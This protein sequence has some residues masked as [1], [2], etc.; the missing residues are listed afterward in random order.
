MPH[1]I[2]VDHPDVCAYLSIAAADVSR[3][4][5]EARIGPRKGKLAKPGWFTVSDGPTWWRAVHG[6]IAHP[7][8]VASV[9]GKEGRMSKYEAERIFTVAALVVSNRP[10]HPAHWAFWAWEKRWEVANIVHEVVE[11]KPMRIAIPKGI[12][13]INPHD[14][15]Y[16]ILCNQAAWCP[17]DVPFPLGTLRTYFSNQRTK[18]LEKQSA[19]TECA[20]EQGPAK[21]KRKTP[22]DNGEMTHRGASRKR[23]KR[24]TIAAGSATE[25]GVQRADSRSVTRARAKQPVRQLPMRE[26]R[27]TAR[28]AV[29]AAAGAE[30][31]ATA[32][33][34]GPLVIKIIPPSKRAGEVAVATE[35]TGAPSECLSPLQ[36]AVKK[37]PLGG[38]RTPPSTQIIDTCFGSSPLTEPPSSPACSMLSDVSHSSPAP[39][40]PW[41]RGH[42]RASSAAESDC[43]EISLACS[44]AT[45]VPSVLESDGGSTRPGTPREMNAKAS[46]VLGEAA[47]AEENSIACRMPVRSSARI[48]E[49]KEGSNTASSL[50]SIS[51]SPPA[52]KRVKRRRS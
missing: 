45:L 19:D 34:S 49:R 50:S 3:F 23:P 28:A 40:R 35:T 14:S 48:Q 15:L 18:A 24:E 31:V 10:T 22:S 37:L 41:Q 38:Y 36:A 46:H 52:V 7:R 11:E 42:R 44:T 2:T 33:S 47:P 30:E 39:G 27:A 5:R 26:T 43:T 25:T 8:Y 6:G 13:W 1:I 17:N 16:F 12:M 9:L 4:E 21:G 20:Q 32:A 29:K 51:L